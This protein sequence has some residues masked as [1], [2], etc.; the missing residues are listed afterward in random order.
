MHMIGRRRIMR[1]V[2]GAVGLLIAAA[3]TV[4]AMGTAH[5]ASA[6][7][8]LADDGVVNSRD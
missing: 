3:A 5:A 1:R 4:F 2:L 8:S 6:H 7:H